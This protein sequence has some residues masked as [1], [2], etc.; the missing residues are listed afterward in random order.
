MSTPSEGKKPLSL[1]H[2]LR[3]K[4]LRWVVTLLLGA[5]LW[6]GMG[7]LAEHARR[8]AASQTVVEQPCT[9]VVTSE[10]RANDGSLKRQDTQKYSVAC[11]PVKAEP[12]PTWAW[13]ALF[14]GALGVAAL[15][16]YA[17]GV[18]GFL[19]VIFLAFTALF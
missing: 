18:V 8:H 9:R 2:Y 17:G 4:Y 6:C 12:M 16:I 7:V 13:W 15:T 5:A 14:T 1:R 11:E 3:W 19:E 10:V